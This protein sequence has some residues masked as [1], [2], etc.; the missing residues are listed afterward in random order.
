MLAVVL[1]HLFSELLHEY[2]AHQRPLTAS[3][4]LGVAVPPLILLIIGRATSIQIAASRP[5]EEILGI[6]TL[7]V[8][9]ALA[10]RRAGLRGLQLILVSFAG[11]VIGLVVI[12]L[13]IVL[14][15]H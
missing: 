10:G 4:W 3:E 1:A 11:G 13:Q 12:V 15:P 2:A 6:V 14:K 7:I 9:A 8:L 5:V